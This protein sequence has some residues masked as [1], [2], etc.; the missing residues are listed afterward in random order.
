M[1]PGTYPLELY[2]GD[3]YA[4]QFVLWLDA[5]Q[6]QPADLDGALAF[7]E[8]RNTAGGTLYLELE[9]IVQAPNTINV[10]L[11]ADTWPDTHISKGVWDL[12]VSYLSGA[13]QTVV[14]GPV[15]IT[16]DVTVPA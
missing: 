16:R 2:R 9:C 13:V 8:I 15:K 3:S 14:A 1:T 11:P 4:W 12:Q 10:E 6:T 5:G 7:A